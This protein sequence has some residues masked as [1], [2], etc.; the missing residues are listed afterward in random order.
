MTMNIEKMKDHLAKH[1]VLEGELYTIGGLGGGEVDGIECIDG[2]WF[3]YFSERGKKRNLVE[4]ASEA[5]ACAYIIERATLLAK[6]Y[7]L[8]ID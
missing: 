6:D 8:W 3:N 7:N 1:G 5:E 2:V 4:R